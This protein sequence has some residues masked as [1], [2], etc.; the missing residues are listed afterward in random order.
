[1]SEILSSLPLGEGWRA[2]RAGWG[3]SLA[4]RF[5]PPGHSLTLVATLPSRGGI[6]GRPSPG[7]TKKVIRPYFF[8]NGQREA[9]SGWKA[10]SAGIV[11]LIL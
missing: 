4:Q 11:L 10:S 7:M 1:M 9:E 2:K 8:T 3:E 6:K 5:S